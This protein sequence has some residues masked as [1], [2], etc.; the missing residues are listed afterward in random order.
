MRV[1]SVWRA[2]TYA[3]L[4]IGLS[5]GYLILRGASWQ[6]S[7]QLHTLME[8]VA[9]LLALTVGTIALLRFYGRKNNTFLFIGSGFLGTAF[10]D[11]YHAIVTSS[12]FASDFPSA[13]AS[14]IPWSWIAS[15]IFLSSLMWL[16]WLAWKR[17]ARSNQRGKV[18][19][20]RVYFAVA[21][22]TISSFLFF[23]F[24]PLPRAYYPNLVFHRPEEF[25]PAFFFLMA[26]LGYLRKGHWKYDQFEHWLVLSLIVGFIGQAMFMSFSGQLF[27]LEFDAAHLLKKISYICVLTG[28]L[29]SMHSL[30]RQAEEGAEIARINDSLEHEIA[31]RQRAEE[32]ARLLADESDVLARIGRIVS[33]S[34]NVQEIFDQLGTEIKKLIPLDR[35]VIATTDP[36]NY[37]VNHRIVLGVE[38]DEFMQ[39][40]TVSLD[41]TY[42]EEVIRMR[43]P[44]L[45]QP[46]DPSEIVSRYPG[47]APLVQTGIRSLISAPL[48]SNNEAVGVLHIRSFQAAAYQDRHVEL[49]G[50]VA[51]QIAGAL[52]SAQLYAERIEAEER[53]RGYTDELA[54][55]NSELQQFAY[56]A[57][58]DLREPLRKVSSFTQLLARRYR[59]KLDAAADEFIEFAVDGAKRMEQL[60]EDLLAY[61]RVGTT[62]RTLEPIDSTAAFQQA[63]ANCVTAIEETAASVTRDELPTVE[64]DPAQLRQVFQNLIANAVKFR[65]EAPPRVHASAR[66]EGQEWVFSVRDNGIGIEVEFAERIFTIFQRLH[67]REDYAGTGIGLAICKKIVEGHGGRIWVESEPGKGSTFRFTIPAKRGLTSA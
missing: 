31:E 15:R 8:T 21:L 65:R 52:A 47:L 41:G 44:V 28:L 54:R 39:G 42:A 37:S 67:S 13:P 35:L 57:S 38:A 53:L 16:S 58:H 50:R 34:L 2:T 63:V 27:D 14:L 26:L 51:D 61:S 19:E 64:A 12:H 5:V 22:L 9:S 66:L 60:I 20:R 29:V 62:D 56:V 17:E 4:A 49:T 45:L 10:L 36:N 40:D 23:A 55:S 59:G 48:I 43:G 46:D 7:A 24:V 6:G 30:F 18:S 11:G 33:S 32:R 1:P 25:V 3:A